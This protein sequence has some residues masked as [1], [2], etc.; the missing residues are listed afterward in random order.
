MVAALTARRSARSFSDAPVELAD[1]AAI[2]HLAGGF[3]G[4][5]DELGTGPEGYRTSPSAGALHPVE[6]YVRARR[7]RGLATGTYHYL[8]LEG[9]L[10]RVGDESADIDHPSAYGDQP[11]PALSP[12]TLLLTA[13]VA[14]NQWRYRTARGYRD[15]LLEAGHVSQTILLLAVARGLGAALATAVRDE[16]LERHLECDG[17]SEVVL[18][19]TALGHPTMQLAP[20][21]VAPGWL[22]G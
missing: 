20:E 11:W 22:E 18:G 21:P 4:V 10:E 16:T 2:L 5:F 7:V 12:V 17:A 3:H 14:R 13:V 15:V 9:R 1:L 19:V 6:L 8:G